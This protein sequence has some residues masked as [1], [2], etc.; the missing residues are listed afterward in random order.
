MGRIWSSGGFTSEVV[1]VK[2]LINTEFTTSLAMQ[3][4]VESNQ[5]RILKP[6]SIRFKLNQLWTAQCIWGYKMM[7]ILQ[8]L[9]YL[10]IQ[11]HWFKRFAQWMKIVTPSDPPPKRICMLSKCV[12]RRVWCLCGGLCLCFRQ[13]VF[14]PICQDWSNSSLTLGSGLAPSWSDKTQYDLIGGVLCSHGNWS[15]LADDWELSVENQG[16]CVS[17]VRSHN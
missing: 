5:P 6:L 3:A 4:P 16:G 13:I 17:E 15:I 10:I 14:L 9:F 2:P 12:Y 11:K 1:T 8:L 7:Y